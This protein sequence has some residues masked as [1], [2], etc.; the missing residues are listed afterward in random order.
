MAT[1]ESITFEN[2]DGEQVTEEWYFSLAE[3][4]LAELPIMRDGNHEQILNEIIQNKKAGDWLDI[5]KMVIF[6]SVGRREDNLLIKDEETRR[7]FEYGGAYREFFSTLI[8]QNDAG[9]GF[10]RSTLPARLSKKLDEV[11]AN[12]QRE[13]TEEE[14]LAMTD[15]EFFGTFGRDQKKYSREVLLVAL[16]RKNAAPAV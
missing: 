11:E 4:D 1:K 8:A 7:Q 10:F 6:A 2:L 9:Y 15:D 16:R 14:M 3:S 5:L 12:Q 13:Y